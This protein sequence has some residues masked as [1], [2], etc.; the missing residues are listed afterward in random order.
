V[1]FEVGC[2]VVRCE[3][4]MSWSADRH[5]LAWDG[6]IRS[7]HVRGA[8]RGCYRSRQSRNGENRTMQADVHLAAVFAKAVCDH[9]SGVREESRGSVATSSC[10][11]RAAF[12]S[13][14]RHSAAVSRELSES[15]EQ[16]LFAE[17]PCTPPDT[18]D[19]G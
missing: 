3:S 4:V 11:A 8:V 17:S 7:Y 18:T 6:P 15:A 5:A 1:S 19:D 9:D 2:G 14:F 16:K 13:L 10:R 12:G